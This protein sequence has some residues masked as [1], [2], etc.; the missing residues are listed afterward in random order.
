MKYR[1]VKLGGHPANGSRGASVVHVVKFR[2]KYIL[3]Y[4]LNRTRSILL[5]IE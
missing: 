2:L 1:R 4:K 5:R 3:L